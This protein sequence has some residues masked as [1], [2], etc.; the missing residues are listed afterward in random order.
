MEYERFLRQTGRVV[1]RW[2][3]YAGEELDLCKLYNAVKRHGYLEG[4]SADRKWPAIARLMRKDGSVE[5]SPNAGAI[6]R[7]LYQKYLLAYEIFERDPTHHAHFSADSSSEEEGGD[8]KPAARRKKGRGSEQLGLSEMDVAEA[9]LELGT[10]KVA[11]GR[12]KG[13]SLAAVME[14]ERRQDQKCQACEG[15]GHEDKMIL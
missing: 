12:G 2:P 11:G 3:L 7:Q 13:G 9:F 1:S 6:L 14:A 10:E 8:I 5:Q 15:P 4:V